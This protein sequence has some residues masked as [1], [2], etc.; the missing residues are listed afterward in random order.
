[1]DPSYFGDRSKVWLVGHIRYL[2]WGIILLVVV[3]LFITKK[4]VVVKKVGFMYGV[5]KFFCFFFFFLEKLCLI[6]CWLCS[7]L[8]L[9]IISVG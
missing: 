7:L 2:F 3:N 4:I 9:F 5:S 6:C 1:M 8:F